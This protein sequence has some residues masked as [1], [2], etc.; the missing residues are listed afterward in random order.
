[1][2]QPRI[3][4]GTRA[5]R[6]DRSVK[7]GALV[8]GVVAAGDPQQLASWRATGGVGCRRGRGDLIVLAEHHQQR[9]GD[10]LGVSSRPVEAGVQGNARADLIWPGVPVGVE[11]RQSGCRVRCGQQRELSRLAGDRDCVRR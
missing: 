2:G 5:L 7:A 4:R 8:D 1:M 11:D 3:D 9:T 6:G 10:P